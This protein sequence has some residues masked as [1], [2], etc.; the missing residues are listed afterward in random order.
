[1]C[2]VDYIPGICRGIIDALKDWGTNHRS[3]LFGI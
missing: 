3:K 1:M 2:Y